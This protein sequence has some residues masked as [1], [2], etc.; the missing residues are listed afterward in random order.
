MTDDRFCWPILLAEKSANFV[1]RP[2]FLVKSII[3]CYVAVWRCRVY[4]AASHDA[5]SSAIADRR[6]R[7]CDHDTKSSHSANDSS[8]ISRHSRR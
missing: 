4:S 3:G 6:R 8:T 5:V 2:T 7:T 1:D